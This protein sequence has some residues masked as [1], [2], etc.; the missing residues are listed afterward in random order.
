M[1][2]S[3][4]IQELE[5]RMDEVTTMKFYKL[6]L[7]QRENSFYATNVSSSF[8]FSLLS[9]HLLLTIIRKHKEFHLVLKLLLGRRVARFIRA[10]L[11]S[12]N[13]DDLTFN[14]LRS[15]SSG[16]LFYNPNKH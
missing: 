9:V 11:Q 5:A 8:I 7:T 4:E 14:A 12:E 1:C 3:W 2:L 10:Q 13:Y 6:S 16:F 15:N